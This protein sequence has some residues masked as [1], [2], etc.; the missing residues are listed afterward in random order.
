[1]RAWRPW[2]TAVIDEISRQQRRGKRFAELDVAGDGQ[3]LKAPA[4]LSEVRG[5]GGA[6]TLHVRQLREVQI[7]ASAKVAVLHRV[8]G[9]ERFA[10]T[11]F[12]LAEVA[13]GLG[14]PAQDQLGPSH[15]E[16]PVGAA[17]HLETLSSELG[18]RLEV[19][20]DP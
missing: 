8:E 10:Q 9:S 20:G 15:S 6:I 14:D 13:P 2:R 3:L 5:D 7:C 18:G 16:R 11:R 1:M 19:P 4:C 17:R 12:G